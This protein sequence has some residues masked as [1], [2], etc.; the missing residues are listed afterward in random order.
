MTHIADEL[1]DLDSENDLQDYLQSELEAGG[2]R[3]DDEVYVRKAKKRADII[4]EH[5]DFGALGIEIKFFR[6]DSGAVISEA[7]HQIVSRYRGQNYRSFGTVD[8]W[9]ICP[10]FKDTH[11]ESCDDW[12]T[13]RARERRRL[14]Q[15]LFCRNGVGFIAL[16]ASELY[17]AFNQG[18]NGWRIPFDQDSSYYDPDMKKIRSR[19]REKMANFSYGGSGTRSCQYNSSGGCTA[20]ATEK[21]EFINTEVEVCQYHAQAVEKALAF[22]EPIEKTRTQD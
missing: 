19:V 18:G 3:T 14:T 4:A 17:V 8:L 15:S 10:C 7:H 16:R 6:G 13:E 12:Y 5:P 20:P 2:W 1:T 22:P 21:V 9:A 11:D